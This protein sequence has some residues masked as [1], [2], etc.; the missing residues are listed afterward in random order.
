MAPRGAE[1]RSKRERVRRIGVLMAYGEGDAEG[2]SFTAAF[3]HGFQELGW[4]NGRNLRIDYRWAAGDVER[5]RALAKELVELQPDAIVAHTTPVTAA[6][7]RTTRTIPVVMAAVSDPVGDGFVAS[8]SRPGGNITGFINIESSMG[9]KWLELVNEIAPRVRRAAIMFNPDTAPA[10]GTYFLGSFESAAQT[11]AI[12][13]IKAAV[14]SDAD[15]IRAIEELGRA[16][17]GGL[18]ATSDGFMTVHRATI[19]SQAARNNV[20]AVYH[21]AV[22]VKDGGLLSYGASVSDIFYRCAPYIDR[23]RDVRFWHKADIPSCDCT[24]PLLGVK[25][26]CLFALHMSAFDPKRTW[27]TFPSAGLSRYDA[28]S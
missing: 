9:G 21:I 24:C 11:L 25:R 1:A 10:R 8:L 16:P 13:P 15:I 3:V 6:V 23:R 5:M 18:V 27:R 4:T 2:Q 14:R 7:Q 20:P 28:V 17:G 26:T 22:S 12:E 19:I